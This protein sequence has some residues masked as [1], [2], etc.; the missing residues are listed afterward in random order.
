MTAIAFAERLA[1]K[2]RQIALFS[3][4]VLSS[5]LVVQIQKMPESSLYQIDL[6][7]ECINIF[8]Y[9]LQIWNERSLNFSLTLQGIMFMFSTYPETFPLDKIKAQAIADFCEEA[10]SEGKA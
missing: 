3:M 4:T 9:P 5:L 7:L 6:N 10:E 8:A 1:E 2:R